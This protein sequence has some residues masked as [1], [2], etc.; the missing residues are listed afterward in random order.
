MEE[1]RCLHC[2]T[3]IVGRKDKKFCDVHCRSAYHHQ[4]K[5]L[6][7]ESFK[8]S[9]ERILNKNRKILKGILRDKQKIVSAEL[10]KSS[11]FDFKYFTHCLKNQKGAEYRFCF[12]YG[13]LI[14]EGAEGRVL[15]VRS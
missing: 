6:R 4:T 10:L 15:V 9:I 12:E 1:R 11:G 14:L 3:K 5:S 2:S 13:Y 7:E 8:N